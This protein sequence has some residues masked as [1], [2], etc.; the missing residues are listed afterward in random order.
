M[1]KLNDFHNSEVPA[2]KMSRAPKP[3][4]IPRLDCTTWKNL[5]HWA[6]FCFIRGTVQSGIKETGCVWNGVVF[7][8]YRYFFYS[9]GL[10]FDSGEMININTRNE[11]NDDNFN[12]KCE[13]KLVLIPVQSGQC[14][15]YHGFKWIPSGLFWSGKFH[16][17]ILQS[18]LKIKIWRAVQDWGVSSWA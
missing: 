9:P 7:F 14:R 13:H 16:Q 15:V 12:K 1:L 3:S 18:G 5:G 11:R 17:D 6:V 4:G 8:R 2:V 10:N